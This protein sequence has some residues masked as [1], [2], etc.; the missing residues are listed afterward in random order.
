MIT[1]TDKKLRYGI[2]E[3]KESI[4][5]NGALSINSERQIEDLNGSF[6]DLEGNYLASFNYREYQ[7]DKC[8]KSISNVSIDN[9]T[10]LDTALDNL[11]VDIKDQLPE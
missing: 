2:E 7:G 1:F 5:M 3:T 11:I 6:Y 9:F 8:D 10:A 4:K